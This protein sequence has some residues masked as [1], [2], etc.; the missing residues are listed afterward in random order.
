LYDGTAFDGWQ[1]QGEKRRTVSGTLSKAL[2]K[3]FNGP[4]YVWGAGRTDSGVHAQGQG[5]HFDVLTSAVANMSAD[6]LEPRQLQYV[7]NRIL[8]TDLR[9]CNI[10]K[11]GP[12]HEQSS[13]RHGF[14]AT[15]SAVSKMYVYRFCT[16]TLV[17]PLRRRVCVHE[18]RNIDISLLERCLA[19]FVGSHD[20]RAFTNRFEHTNKKDFGDREGVEY[21]T[22]RTVLS[23]ELRQEDPGYYA[24]HIHLQ[25][26]VYRMV[27]NIVSTS[28]LVAAGGLSLSQLEMLLKEGLSRSHNPAKSA[29]P[30]GLT[31]EHVFY[32]EGSPLG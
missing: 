1:Y 17:D 31:L 28:L 24:I 10:T 29:H 21:N 11:V 6:A 26:A 8:P 19:L 14:H 9:I 20:F 30:Q 2:T 25:S 22:T 15:K 7:L 3:R 18:Y 5:A 16:N 13:L 12:A 4:V 23:I 32:P 27:R